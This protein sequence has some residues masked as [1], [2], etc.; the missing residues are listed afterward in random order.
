MLRFAR[1]IT[2]VSL[3]SVPAMVFAQGRFEGVITARMNGQAGGTDV[4]Y[5][6][7]GDQFRMDIGGRGMGMYII[8]DAAKNSS[9]MVMPSQRMY[10]G[11][12][13]G[14]ATPTARKM[15]EIKMTG[16][17]EKIAGVECEHVLLT[18]EDG[19]YDVC[20]AKGLGGFAAMN[21]PM[22]RGPASQSAAWQKLGRDLFP[23]RV[24]KVGES[25]PI[26]E[27]TKIEKKSLD[28]SLFAA[29]EGFTKMDMG[30]M[31]RKPP[32]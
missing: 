12:R 5:S 3:T 4:T 18:G 16:K 1:A 15:P 9:I 29:P 31:G 20:A 27:V 22:G 6:I 13:E 24:Q 17:M 28:H 30:G 10:T 14:A 19:Q 26:F 11:A 8:R 23:L 25:E 7:K 2:V 21:G 32:L